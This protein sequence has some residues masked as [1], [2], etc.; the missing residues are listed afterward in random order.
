MAQ[1]TTA[2]IIYISGKD[3]CNLLKR[4]AGLSEIRGATLFAIS[5]CCQP[6]KPADPKYGIFKASDSSKGVAATVCSGYALCRV[7][8]SVWGYFTSTTRYLLVL[9]NVCGLVMRSTYCLLMSRCRV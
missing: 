6:R 7:L 9:Q 2:K 8:G 5:Q 4:P 3:V 1:C